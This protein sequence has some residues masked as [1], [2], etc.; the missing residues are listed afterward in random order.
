VDGVVSDADAGKLAVKGTV[1][2][3]EK[4]TGT[5]TGAQC[6]AAKRAQAQ[7]HAPASGKAQ[8]S[9]GSTVQRLSRKPD[10]LFEGDC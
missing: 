2:R 4:S 5:G 9:V 6:S 10:S 7:V 1:Q 8:C 3:S